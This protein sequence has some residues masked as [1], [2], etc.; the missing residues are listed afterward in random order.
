MK[1]IP[2]KLLICFSLFILCAGCDENIEAERT[3]A[4]DIDS[5]LAESNVSIHDL[6]SKI[7]IVALD[8][9]YPI[10]NTVHSGLSYL[11]FDGSHFYV[12]DE[13]NYFVNV[14]DSCGNLLQ[15]IDKV[16]RGHGEFTM[17]Y[18]IQYNADLN[19]IEILNPMG[20]ILR[21]SSDSFTYHSEIDFMDH[22]R[23]THNYCRSGTDYILYS[24][25][26]D[27]KLY[28]FNT[29]NGEIISYGYQPPE[30]LRKYIAPQSPFLTINGLSCIYQPYDGLIYKI[31]N[32]KIVPYIKWDLGRY[33]CQLR[34]I[35]Q[36]K[37]NRE[38]YDFI[39]EYSKRHLAAFVNIKSDGYALYSSVIFKGET[40]TLYHNLINGNSYFFNNTLEEIKFL[41]ELFY[42]NVMYKY[43][44]SLYLDEYVRRDILDAS[45]RAEYDEVLRHGGG[46]I[47]K[48]IFK[49]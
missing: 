34:D 11:A 13:K 15:H 44:D 40:Y 48:Y 12:L 33:K 30:Y 5:C 6:F 37:S 25:R 27:D 8:N 47:I 28:S 31:D 10:S 39:L 3:I 21:F 7:E 24:L 2:F 42:D 46:A 17:A 18:Q 14:Y 9:T 4:L 20:K 16:G 38:Y 19:L 35:P 36:N 23:S 26:E 32:D 41:P 45:S 1:Y 49:E 43:V 22:I 29:Y